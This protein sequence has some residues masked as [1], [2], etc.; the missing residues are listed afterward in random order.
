MASFVNLQ[1][2]TELE[3]VAQ[4]IRTILNTPRG[5]APMARDVGISGWGLDGPL[6][7]VRARIRDDIMNAICGPDAKVRGEPRAE[8]TSIE[9]TGDSADGQLSFVV[10]FR[11]KDGGEGSVSSS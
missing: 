10:R 9:F 3:E 2:A 4:N 5:S 6:P 11:L 8:V 7:A 1:P